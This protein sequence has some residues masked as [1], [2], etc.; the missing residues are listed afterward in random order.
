MLAWVPGLSGLDA[1]PRKLAQGIAARTTA[2][3][4]VLIWG[5]LPDAAVQAHRIPAGRFVHQ[6]YL[7]GSWAS[8]DGV[9]D[10]AN[11][12]PYAQRWNDYIDGLVNSPPAIII[13]ASKIVDGWHRRPRAN[14]P[15]SCSRNKH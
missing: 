9:A 12:E 10:P 8:V 7:T 14:A 11:T 2:N 15:S 5:R 4:R 13:D 1:A 3:D 6:A